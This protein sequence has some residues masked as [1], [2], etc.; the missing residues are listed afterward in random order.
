MEQ[1]FD[2]FPLLVVTVLGVVVPLLLQKLPGVTIPIVVGEIAA[3]MLVGPSG[4]NLIHDQNSWLNFLKFFGFAYLMFLS[5]LEIEFSSLM[6]VKEKPPASFWSFL[7]ANPLRAGLLVFALTIVCSAAA[8]HWIVSMNLARDL[9]LMTL[10]L[11]TTSLGVVMPVLKERRLSF[12]PLGQHILVTAGV[13][14]FATVLLVSTY[15]TLYTSG[16]TFEIFFVLIL[17]ALTFLVY[18]LAHLSRLHLPLESLMTE[19]SHATAQLDVRA[20]LALAVIFIAL[21]Q[22]LGVELI[23]GAFL[24]GAIVSLLSAD[25]GSTLRP[26][27][28]ALG[29]GFFIPIFFIMVGVDFNLEA[30]GTGPQGYLLVPLL[31]LVAFL[32]KIVSA[33]A[34]KPMFSW[35]EVLAIGCITSARLSLIIAVSE[36]GLGL[37]AITETMNSAI[38]LVAIVTVVTAPLLFNWLTEPGSERQRKVVII[39]SSPHARLLAQRLRAHDEQVAIVTTNPTFVKEARKIGIEVILVEPGEHL[40]AIVGT[41]WEKS[42]TLVSLADDEATTLQVTLAAKTRLGFENIIAHVQDAELAERLREDGVVVADPGQALVVTLESL[43]RNPQ[44]FS[45]LA[46]SDL[47]REVR[48]VKMRNPELV[49]HRLRE[50][51]LAGDAL[52]LLLNRNSEAIIPRGFTELKKGDLLTLVGSREAVG[53]AARY[54]DPTG[55][56]AQS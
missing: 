11:S 31:V 20:A 49:G 16:V 1:E 47:E 52:V 33:L 43:V 55:H 27:L 34:Y 50:L 26:K 35:R 23:L 17:L 45:L 7:L 36:I 54:F 48:A 37:G 40:D 24:A 44:A 13:G 19:L 28:N 15:V 25:H 3:G 6:A 14:D 46:Q 21:A 39:G 56:P 9:V 10:I 2:F 38:I 4:M 32:V 30:L 53:K 29:Y 8:A 51:S 5:G 12:T 41:P 42:E 18:R 22:G